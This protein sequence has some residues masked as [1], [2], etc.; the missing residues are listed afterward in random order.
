MKNVFYLSV[1]ARRTQGA[2]RFADAN[3]SDPYAF[4]RAMTHIRNGICEPF[5]NEDKKLVQAIY[6]ADTYPTTQPIDE[7]WAPLLK[8]RPGTTT[9][10]TTAFRNVQ[11]P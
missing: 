11:R 7:R 3:K 6:D 4:N 1:F 5:V 10:Q 9:M 8:L 2:R